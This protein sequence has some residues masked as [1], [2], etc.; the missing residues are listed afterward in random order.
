MELRKEPKA[1]LESK[2]FVFLE[3]GLIIALLLVLGAFQ[4]RS[5]NQVEYDFP[6]T[7]AVFEVEE[8]A[9]VTKQKQ[10]MPKPPP[11]AVL[12]LVTTDQIIDDIPIDVSIDLD[13]P[14]AVIDYS[15]QK[16]A[17]ALPDDVPYVLIP[18]EVAEFPGGIGAFYQFLRNNIRYPVP[19]KE[20]GITGT[21]YIE[22]I[23]GKDGSITSIVL[24]RGIGG[25][26]DEEA[27]RVISIMPR[28]IPAKQQK[29]PVPYKMILPV[30]F[31]LN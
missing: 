12:N 1:N 15:P 22:F 13:E 19:A 26:C 21:V 7:G 25:G 4:Y 16:E 11:Q 23:V 14:V 6:S 20:M 18:E 28:W 5:Y 2:R 3:V 31:S 29:Q 9:P 27:L 8:M 24:K 17:E 30:K 10:E